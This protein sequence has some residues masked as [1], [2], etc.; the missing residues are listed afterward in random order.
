MIVVIFKEQPSLTDLL[1]SLFPILYIVFLS[2]LL[3]QCLQ[4]RYQ[5]DL[6]SSLASLLMSFESV[7]GAFFGWLI[8]HQVM[9][10]KEIFGCALVFAA[11]LIAESK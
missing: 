4:I 8:L 2:G 6:D 9:S 1:A 7:F 5:R 11:I 3:A 10:V